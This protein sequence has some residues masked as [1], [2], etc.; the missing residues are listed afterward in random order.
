VTGPRSALRT[1]LRKLL[2]NRLDTAEK[3]PVSSTDCD[4]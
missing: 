1:F 2:L 3:P 4:M